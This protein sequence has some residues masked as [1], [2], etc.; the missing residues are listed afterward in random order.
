VARSLPRFWIA[1]SSI[2][3]LSF[4][5][6][7]SPFVIYNPP[8]FS[9]PPLTKRQVGWLFVLAGAVLMLAAVGA[10]LVRAGRFT[11]FGPAQQQALGGGL[12]LLLFGLSLF[13]LGHR[14]A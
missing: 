3:H 13:P 8:M 11:G 5:I 2:L 4:V 6:F 1:D 14:P 7:H 10:D 9:D 12:L